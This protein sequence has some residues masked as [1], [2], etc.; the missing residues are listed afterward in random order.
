MKR[1]KNKLKKK[2]RLKKNIENKSPP[3]KAL[4]LECVCV[5]PHMNTFVL[6]DNLAHKHI[7]SC[8]FHF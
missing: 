8:P 3:R 7:A 5:H 4:N 1:L 6:H 2:K